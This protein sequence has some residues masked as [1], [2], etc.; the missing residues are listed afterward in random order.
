MWSDNLKFITGCYLNEDGHLMAAEQAGGPSDE[1]YMW[2]CHSEF[3]VDVG[4]PDNFE[5]TEYTTI[6]SYGGYHGFFM[7]DMQE[8]SKQ[9]PAMKS[10]CYVR[11]VPRGPS[12]S[13]SFTA[14]AELHVGTTTVY[15]PH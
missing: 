6:H 13:D 9:I 8:V 11:T 1:G 14:D 7:P 15:V 5:K 3:T 10:K 2:D 12:L 4:T